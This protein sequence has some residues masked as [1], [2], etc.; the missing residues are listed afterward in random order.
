MGPL[1]GDIRD[2][3]R[4]ILGELALDGQIPLKAVGKVVLVGQDGCNALSIGGYR[5]DDRR[6]A[7]VLRE[8]VVPVE[9]RGNPAIGGGERGRSREPETRESIPLVDVVRVENPRSGTDY[10]L[11]IHAISQAQPRRRVP[12]EDVQ[13][14]VAKALVAAIYHGAGKI[15]GGGVRG[16]YIHVGDTPQRVVVGN[17]NLPTKAHRQGELRGHFPGVVEEEAYVVIPAARQ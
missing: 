13:E 16:V 8:T 6:T 3:H 4:E 11:L 12:P 7:E 1:V 14:P 15:A 17:D 10:G 5:V 9:G 2:A